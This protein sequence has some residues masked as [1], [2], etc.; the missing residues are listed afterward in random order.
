MKDDLYKLVAANTAL[1]VIWA[2]ENGKRPPLPFVLLD[3]RQ[4]AA[5][6]PVHTGSLKADDTR[7]LDAAR[8]A[9]VSLQC[10]GAGCFEELD[11]LY[12]RLRTEA[13]AQM[14]DAADAAIVDFEPVQQVPKLFEADYEPQAVGGFRY[15][16]TVSLSEQP[17]AIDAVNLSAAVMP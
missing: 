5:A 16:Y 10:F 2:H 7:L 4:A 14:L 15:R 11:A 3:V 6:W 12:L 13:A 8:E 9:R 1:P 17:G